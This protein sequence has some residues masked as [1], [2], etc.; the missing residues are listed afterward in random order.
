M[1][2]SKAWKEGA[3]AAYR[4]LPDNANP[5]FSTQKEAWL[6]GWNS[7]F[8]RKTL[9]EIAS[10]PAVGDGTDCEYIFFK[11]SGKWMYAGRGRFPRPQTEG[12][13]EIDRDEIIRENGSMP[14]ISTRGS[15][16]IIIINPDEACSVRSAYPR[17]L[18]PE[19]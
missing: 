2:H 14:G 11:P 13:H 1:I 8:K 19:A 16:F 7:G 15:D 10:G 4:G 9:D 12:Y 5:Y 3:E 6:D 18:Q 17:M